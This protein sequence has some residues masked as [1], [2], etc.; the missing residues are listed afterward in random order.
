MQSKKFK[1]TVEKKGELIHPNQKPGEV[2]YGDKFYNYHVYLPHSCDEWVIAYGLKKE[3]VIKD[4][5][6]FILEAQQALSDLEK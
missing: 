3:K 6:V 4:L 2:S 5:K 1:F